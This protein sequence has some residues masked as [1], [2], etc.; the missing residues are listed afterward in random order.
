MASAA[1]KIPIASASSAGCSSFTTN[2][3]TRYFK[4]DVNALEGLGKSAT[5]AFGPIYGGFILILALFFLW[6]SFKTKGAAHWITLI[7]ALLS[8]WQVAKTGMN[9]FEAKDYL[10]KNTT[11]TCDAPAPVQSSYEKAMMS[12]APTQPGKTA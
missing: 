4:K 6:I 8:G 1:A 3:K 5:L 7:L 12:S 9:W 2:G 11:D 10:D